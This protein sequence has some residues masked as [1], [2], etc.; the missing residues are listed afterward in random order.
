MTRIV[1]DKATEQTSEFPAGG[2]ER[3]G[4]KTRQKVKVGSGVLFFFL[5]PPRRGSRG[6]IPAQPP[7]HS[8]PSGS[9]GSWSGRSSEEP[10]GLQGEAPPLTEGDFPTSRNMRPA[11]TFF[12]LL[13]PARYSPPSAFF[14][15]ALNAVRPFKLPQAR[16]QVRNLV[17]KAVSPSHM[18]HS[19][20]VRG[21]GVK[22]QF[23]KVI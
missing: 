13:F 9:R 15:S 4:R 19:P 21:F 20:E 8:L 23:A 2:E 22:F 16:G 10:T 5:L 3:R 6:G 14:V 1:N 17:K 12:F 11:L 18:H 7:I